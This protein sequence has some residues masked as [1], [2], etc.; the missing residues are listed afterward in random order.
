MRKKEITIKDQQTMKRALIL[1]LLTAVAVVARSQN[2]E[3][4]RSDIDSAAIVLERYLSILNYEA[5]R[6]DSVLYI[7]SHA[8]SQRNPSDTIVMKR[9]FLPESNYRT[10]L[11][12]G[13]TLEI[14]LYSN[15]YDTFMRYDAKKKLWF[16]VDVSQY[17]DHFNAYN[18]HGPFHQWKNNKKNIQLRYDG[19]W[20]FNGNQ[21]YRIFV[22]QAEM[23]DRYYMF[24][25]ESGLLFMYDQL[26]SYKDFSRD[27]TTHVEWRAYHEYTPLGASLFPSLESYQYEDDI[28]VTHHAYRYIAKDMKYFTEDCDAGKVTKSSKKGGD[29][30]EHIR[31]RR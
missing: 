15:G 20:N 21:A 17:Y 26:D 12:H 10:E 22:S 7:E 28:V 2:E 8:F 3:T 18:F 25:K 5:I 9:W 14:G 13:D 31:Q 27:E 4:D 16:K 30:H 19:V 29:R 1:I 24:E 23:F 11:W 6:S